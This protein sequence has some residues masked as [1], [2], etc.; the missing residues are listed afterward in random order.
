MLISGRQARELLGEAGISERRTRIALASGLAG[1]VVRSGTAH[2]YEARWVIGLGQRRVVSHEE[3]HERCPVR[4]FVSRRPVSVASGTAQLREEL[5]VIPGQIS[6]YSAM[7][8]WCSD[9]MPGGT[10]FLATVA[11]FVV[12][13]ANVVRA[14]GQHLVLGDPGPWFD[15][16]MGAQLLTGK[17]RQWKFLEPP[18]LPLPGPDYRLLVPRRPD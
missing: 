10:Q 3:I 6:P 17:G 11:G 16:L 8:L 5:S 18:R 15:G 9:A 7:A 13:G 14:R 4:V 12:L 2:L 1:P